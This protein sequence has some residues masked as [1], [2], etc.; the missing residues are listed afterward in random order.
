MSKKLTPWFPCS[1]K[2]VHVGTYEVRL[3]DNY[4]QKYV[5]AY[6][7]QWI[8]KYWSSYGDRLAGVD[9]PGWHKKDEWRGLAVKP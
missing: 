5:E 8:G 4:E 2:P 7:Y 9:R 1:V 3:W 6:M